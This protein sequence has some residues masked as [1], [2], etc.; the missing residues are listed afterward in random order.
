MATLSYSN[1]LLKLYIERRHGSS[2]NDSS[3]APPLT[4]QAY[5]DMYMYMYVKLNQRSSG[6]QTNTVQGL[7]RKQCMKGENM[8]PSKDVKW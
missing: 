7:A 2:Q 8:C 5:T 4:R 1:T 6:A 3:I